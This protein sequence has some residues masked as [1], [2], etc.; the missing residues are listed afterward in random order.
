MRRSEIRAKLRRSG[1]DWTRD[2][3]VRAR[4]SWRMDQGA[5]V[6][7]AA[8]SGEWTVADAH[9]SGV[10]VEIMDSLGEQLLA[11]LGSSNWVRSREGM[12]WR[13]GD[14]RGDALAMQVH[15]GLEG[16]YRLGRGRAICVA[17]GAQEGGGDAGGWE[18]G[19]RRA[20]V[21]LVA[22]V[23]GSGRQRRDAARR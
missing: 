15:A 4:V 7:E 13:A 8:P 5:A 9:Q 1:R 10:M 12:C 11:R 22:A 21:C 3:A 17:M 2:E 16:T 23:V 14:W 18:R 19:R 20:L 6:Q